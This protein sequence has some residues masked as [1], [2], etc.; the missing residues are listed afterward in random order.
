MFQRLLLFCL[1][2]SHRIHD[3]GWCG[4]GKT[5]NFPALEIVIGINSVHRK[6]PGG[7]LS[8]INRW[9]SSNWTYI[10]PNTQLGILLANWQERVMKRIQRS[11]ARETLTVVQTRD[12]KQLD[13]GPATQTQCSSGGGGNGKCG[14]PAATADFTRA[15]LKSKAR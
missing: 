9:T 4:N 6:M 13:G 7:S 14:S 15:L 8:V 10:L 1:K 2:F 11:Q 12:G 5:V 3:L